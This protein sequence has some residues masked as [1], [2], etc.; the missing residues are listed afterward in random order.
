[1]I[2]HIMTDIF[3]VLDD[4]GNIR[5]VRLQDISSQCSLTVFALDKNS[6]QITPQVCACVAGGNMMV[7]LE[8]LSTSSEMRYFPS[9]RVPH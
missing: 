5:K 4:K 2:V 1:M 7:K 8:L 6:N 3:K 9:L